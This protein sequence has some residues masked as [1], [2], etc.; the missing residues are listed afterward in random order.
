MAQALK[1]L[2]HRQWAGGR[3]YAFRFLFGKLDAEKTIPV[4]RTLKKGRSCA[5]SIKNTFPVGVPINQD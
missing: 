5:I 4:A 1:A 3:I 2:F